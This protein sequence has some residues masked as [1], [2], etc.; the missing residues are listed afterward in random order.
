MNRYQNFCS[1]KE[2]FEIY[3]LVLA[4]RL[5]YLFISFHITKMLYRNKTKAKNI[6]SKLNFQR[7]L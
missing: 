6:I 1:D 3:I 7:N 4:L 5:K 2:N